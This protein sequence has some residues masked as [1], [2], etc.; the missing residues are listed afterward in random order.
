MSGQALLDECQLGQAYAVRVES[1]RDVLE[2]VGREVAMLDRRITAAVADDPGYRAVQ[3]IHGVGPVL[4]AVFVAEISDVNRFPGP[5]QLCSWAGLTPRHRE[6]DTTVHRGRITKQGSRRLTAARKE[7]GL[8]QAALA[9]RVGIHVT[10]VRRYEA[11]SSAPT[12]GVLRKIAM[13]LNVTTDSLV[14]DDGERGPRRR[15][16]L[17]LRGHR[18]PRR[19]R[20]ED[21]QEPHRGGVAAPRGQ[22][23]GLG[24]VSRGRAGRPTTIGGVVLRPGASQLRG[25][26]ET[27]KGSSTAQRRSQ[28]ACR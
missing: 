4:A 2:V 10:Q 25:R 3:S 14:F 21:A 7:R 18:A 27:S 16:A 28:P 8:T 9:E 6:S 23:V 19:G 12:L 11:G 13:S 15:A 26:R 20:A 1:L 22:A 17:G 5:R 24:V